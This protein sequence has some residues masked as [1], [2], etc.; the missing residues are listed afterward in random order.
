MNGTSWAAAFVLMVAGLFSGRAEAEPRFE[1]AAC[2][3]AAWTDARCGVVRVP[4]NREHPDRRTIPVYVAILPSPGGPATKPPV[5][6]IVGGPGDGATIRVQGYLTIRQ[7]YRQGR[8]IVLIDQRG[9]GSSNALVCSV[10]GGTSDL[11]ARL[12]PL[13]AVEDVRACADELS[14]NADLSQYVT[15]EMVR[16]T[17]AVRQALGH[18]SIDLLAAS[19]GTTL[20]LQYIKAYPERVR[21]AVLI[22]AIPA[23]AMPPSRHALAGFQALNALLE[24][25]DA[26]PVCSAAFP[27]PRGD[28]DATLSR[29]ADDEADA[30]LRILPEVFM[31]RLRSLMYRSAD[32]R[33]VPYILHRAAQGDFAPFLALYGTRGEPVA[34][35]DAFADGLYL[36]ITC[37][38]SFGAFDYEALAAQARATP[39]GDYRLRQQRAACDV[40]PKGE[41]APDHFTPVSAQTPTLFL[42]GR[43]DAVA[44]PEWAAEAARHMPNA[45]HVVMAVGNHA[46]A[47]M[48]GLDT[49]VD[50]LIVE[51]FDRG[52]AIDADARCIAGLQAP[53]FVTGPPD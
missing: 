39:L 28:L 9:T 14:P 8:D 15:R 19:Y 47:G 13:Y 24:D 36:M 27:N 41:L 22:G 11:Q 6:D 10:F 38:E 17:E 50:R 30:G 20:A 37:S 48:P 45:R 3:N 12:S 40:L 7:S 32:S 21:S 16:D 49:C 42:S 51:V 46:L 23:F 2:R 31:E 33:R 34:R 52:S 5:Y 44:S 25:C 4:E 43:L 18:E 35:E 26:D 29:L 1:P 53:P